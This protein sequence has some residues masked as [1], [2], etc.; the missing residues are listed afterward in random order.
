ML[1]GVSG[2]RVSRGWRQYYNMRLAWKITISI[3]GV[4][5]LLGGALYLW[6]LQAAS[7]SPLPGDGIRFGYIRGF[8]GAN[9]SSMVFD[10]A[11]WLAGNDAV[12]AAIRAGRCTEAT[13]AT[14]LPE[15]FFILNDS[16]STV[17]LEL[18]ADVM[19]VAI[20]PDEKNNLSEKTLS[21]DEL[22]ALAE[23]EEGRD[24]PYQIWIEQGRVTIIE[25]V[26]LP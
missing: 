7:P 9:D 8:D 13:R 24:E 19:I 23:S 25:R 21:V 10:E 15:D 22:K 4:L 3:L 26:Y 20:E 18:G 12:D 6:A 11:R 16:T 17:A 1:A 2:E 5:V 14:C